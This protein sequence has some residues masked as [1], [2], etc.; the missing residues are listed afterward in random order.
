MDMT[1]RGRGRPRNED[2]PGYVPPESCSNCRR[3]PCTSGL[4]ERVRKQ[5]TGVKCVNYMRFPKEGRK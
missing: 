2:R 3:E 1:K 5:F 4:S